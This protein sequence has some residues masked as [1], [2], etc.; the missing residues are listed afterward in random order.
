[1]TMTHT[2]IEIPD[3]SFPPCPSCGEDA[4]RIEF[5]LRCKPIGSFSLTG[6]QMKLSAQEWPWLVCDSCGIEAEGKR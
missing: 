2:T 6:A 5:R 1:M 3:V 4:L